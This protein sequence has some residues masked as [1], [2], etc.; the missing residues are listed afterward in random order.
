MILRCEAAD[1]EGWALDPGDRYCPNCGHWQQPVELLTEIQVADQWV[2]SWVLGSQPARLGVVFRGRGGSL[3]LSQLRLP[4]WLQ[5]DP[6]SALLEPGG[7]LWM[8]LRVSQH[9]PEGVPGRISLQEAELEVWCS[10]PA[11]AELHWNPRLL[12][13]E[14]SEIEGELRLL[15]GALYVDCLPAGWQTEVALPTVLSLR[16]GATLPV[17]AP[18]VE[19]PIHWHLGSTVVTGQIDCR[20]A[21]TFTAPLR[22]AWCL[23]RFPELEVPIEAQQGPVEIEQVVCD[24]AEVEFP[25]HLEGE[26]WVRL[27]A[28]AELA[29]DQPAEMVIHLSDGRKRSVALDLARPQPIAFPGWLLVDFGGTASAAALVEDQG[30][31]TQLNLEGDS[32]YL[33]SGIAYFPGHRCRATDQP[34]PNVIMEAKRNLGRGSFAFRLTLPE[35]GEILER[36]PQQAAQD[37]F[38]VLLERIRPQLGLYRVERCCL[39][40]PAAFS[41]RQVDELRQAWLAQLDCQLECISEPLAAAYFYLTQ[42]SLPPRCWRLLL[43]DFGGTTSDVAV[44]QVDSRSRT[45]VSVELE[46]VGGDRWFG[47]QDISDRVSALLPPEQRR[48]AETVKRNYSLAEPLP[49]PCEVQAPARTRLDSEVEPRL[50]LS[51]PQPPL[52]PDLI[53]LSGRGSHYPLIGEWLQKQFP[54]VALERCSQPK[55]CVVLGARLHPEVMRSAG[56]R[57]LGEQSTWLHFP[58]SPRQ[59]VC[60]TRLG[61][62]VMGDQGARFHTMVS[63]GQPLPCQVELTPL[64]LLAGPNRVEVVENLGTEA[65]Y[66]LPDGSDNTQLVL[67]E[68]VTLRIERALDPARTRL[69]WELSADYRLRLTVWDDQAQIAAVGPFSLWPNP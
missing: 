5:L 6:P 36:T 34:G 57:S 9:P 38:G 18:A 56:P 16:S 30:R 49:L 3:D 61:I 25:G 19:G 28:A 37:Y 24:V 65:A 14:K 47:G 4:E 26:G 51:L 69:R 60:T 13:P 2:T 15:E 11:R 35:T 21:G 46:H 50:R 41:P 67:L 54:G 59:P 8:P 22:Q 7:S 12:N 44:L 31:L 43:Y 39:T 27:R 1:C 68:H 55:D 42:R 10:S 17:R 63:L 32:P 45:M 62:K 23:T 58:E 53:V 52:Q 29:A 40:H 20:W 48:W 33:P 66:L 64:S